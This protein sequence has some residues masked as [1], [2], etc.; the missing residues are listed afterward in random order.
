M[1]DRE[2]EK[3][4]RIEELKENLYSR[5]FKGNKER[6]SELRKHNVD[7]KTDWSRNEE[8][9]LLAHYIPEP[10]REMP[11]LKKLFIASLVFFG[12]SLL[13]A[14]FIFLGGRNVISSDNVEISVQAPVSIAGGEELPLQ[15]TISNKNNTVL[16]ATHLFIQYPEG[17]RKADNIAEELKRYRELLGDLAPG[18]SF[19]KKVSAVLF[20]EAGSVKTISVYAEYRVKGSNAIFSSKEK[21]YDVI[22]SAAPVALTVESLKEIN[23]G[24]KVE[25]LVT[26]SSNSTNIIKSLM[27]RAEYPF[28]FTFES[29]SPKASAGSNI[30]NLGDLKP[31]TKKTIRIQGKLEGEDEEERTFKFTSGIES[32]EDDKVLATPFLT[33]SHSLLIKRPFIGV[34]L[35]LNGESAK[36]YAA[37]TD[38]VVRGDIAWQN[39]L[40]TQITE[41]AIEM[42]LIGDIFNKSSVTTDEGFYRSLD[43]VIIWDQTNARG[44]DVIQPGDSGRVSFA[45]KTIGASSG[46]SGRANPEMTIEINVRGKRIGDSN[47]SEEIHSTVVKKVKISSDLALSSRLLHSTGIFSNTGPIPPKA[48]QESTYTVVWSLANSTNNLS[49]VKVNAQLPSYVKWKGTVSPE[50]EK[51]SYNQSTGEIIWDA[52]SIDAGVGYQI[53]PRE[54]SFQI[55]L[56]PS[57]SQVGS[58]PVVVGPARAVG[59]DRFT[60]SQVKSDLRSAQTTADLGEMTSNQIR[61]IVVQ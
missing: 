5:N 28:G 47:V 1:A 50:S 3:R 38:E 23:S 12:V 37:G 7:V 39:N 6:K 61:G 24:Q 4:D 8:E 10:A 25:F 44:L 27:L 22:I 26:V 19:L 46:L 30:W 2:G 48:D 59:E 11:M 21:R 52:G 31:G 34:S 33:Y 32:P 9:N 18:E 57:I 15:I 36:D 60:S 58:A 42:R 16:E 55:S 17:T 45:F 14:G 43:N 54:I 53:R 29:A 40:P 51:F 20:G 41:A 13:V 56:V 35:S 49:N